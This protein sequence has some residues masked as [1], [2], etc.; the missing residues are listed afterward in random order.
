MNQADLG[1]RS[2]SGPEAVSAANRVRTPGWLGC[3]AGTLLGLLGTA[4]VIGVF[5]LAFGGELRLGQAPLSQTRVW[6][7]DHDHNQ[8]LGLAVSRVDP[9]LSASAERCAVTRV[10][11]LMWRDDGSSHPASFC[12]CYRL[13]G[14]GWVESGGCPK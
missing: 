4:L 9:S 10:M 13:Q 1:S 12:A 2:D 7:I 14:G 11:F 8:G 3:L 5:V 6:M